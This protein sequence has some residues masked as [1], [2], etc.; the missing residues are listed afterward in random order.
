MASVSGIDAT[1]A[2]VARR[3]SGQSA[4]PFTLEEAP[5]PESAGAADAVAPGAPASLLGGLLAVQ[6]SLSER[7]RDRAA[8]HHGEALLEE[9]ARLQV[10]L[11]V[12]EIG[13]AASSA[14]ILSRLADL[15]AR[16]PETND[17]ALADALAAVALR[18]QVELARREVAATAPAQSIGIA[19]A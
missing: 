1:R 10:S 5:S 4:R 2:P 12:P 8:S 11:L 16:I 19:Q 9:L 17:A 7:S 13:A 18:A 3:L 6:E 15:T 14:A